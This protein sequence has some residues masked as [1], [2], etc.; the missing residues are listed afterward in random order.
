MKIRGNFS[1]APFR[2]L[3]LVAASL[4]LSTAQAGSFTVNP[5][6]VTLSATQAVAA[7]T[8]NNVGTDLTVIQLE[9]SSWTQHDGK[10]T[11]TPTGD[12]L[13]TPPI[14]TVPPGASRIIRVG[15]RRPADPQHEL[16]YRLLLREV[17]PPEPMAQALRVALALSIPV[18]VDPPKLP[19]AQVQWRATRMPDG[20]IRLQARNTGGSHIQL[21]RLEIA[22]AEG[23][24]AIATR[25]M[26]DYLLPQT[27]RE[28]ILSAKS[29]PTSG[30][31]LR[32]S[33]QADIGEV[34]ADVTLE[35]ESREL[36]PTTPS[37]AAR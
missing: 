37:T 33:S 28:W 8:V 7:M 31:V 10:D 14:I 21:G 25:N 26:A 9:T 3:A 11:L 35:D 23:G 17:P 30:K 12:V 16:T 15:L 13:A 2:G 1:Q 19:A 20:N 5:V 6:R 32:I 4:W 24:A 29:T 22:L 18:F 34:K 36:N 27:E